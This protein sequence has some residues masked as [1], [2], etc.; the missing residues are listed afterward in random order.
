MVNNENDKCETTTCFKIIPKGRRI[1]LPAEF[2]TGE[3]IKVCTVEE[4]PEDSE[5]ENIKIIEPN[6]QKLSGFKELFDS[7]SSQLSEF[8][9]GLNSFF[10]SENKLEKTPDSPLI[11]KSQT[12]LT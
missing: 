1:L 4:F 10:E 5:K 11:Q 8:S 12:P 7:F 3:K 9:K 2:K 6:N